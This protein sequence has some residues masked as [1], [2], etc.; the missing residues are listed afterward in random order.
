MNPEIDA[1]TVLKDLHAGQECWIVGKGPSLGNLRRD[2]FGDGPVITINEAILIVQELG[3]PNPI[4]SLQKDGYVNVMVRP[5]DD[6]TLILQANLSESW[7][8]DHPKRLILDPVAA[9]GFKVTEMSIRMCIALA[10]LMGCY[11]ISFLCCDSLVHDDFRVFD[12]KK[13]CAVPNPWSGA[14]GYVR[15]L[16]QADVKDMPHRFVIPGV[17]A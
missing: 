8:P 3:L 6:V 5:K 1:A 14:Y 7:F 10:K 12:V 15:P 9:W 2:Y 16:V 4:Y 17:Q 13:G 11:R